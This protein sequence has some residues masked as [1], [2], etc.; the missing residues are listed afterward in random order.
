MPTR[1]DALPKWTLCTDMC[2]GGCWDIA[3][4]TLT[5]DVVA[6]APHGPDEADAIDIDLGVFRNVIEHIWLT[7]GTQCL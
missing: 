3:T 5:M 2:V 7:N 1:D 4:S 6:V